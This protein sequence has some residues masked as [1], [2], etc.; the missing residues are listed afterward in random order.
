MG[1]IL[2]DLLQKQHHRG[3][4]GSRYTDEYVITDSTRPYR[5]QFYEEACQIRSCS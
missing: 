2:G 3:N 1:I 5:Y 4:Q